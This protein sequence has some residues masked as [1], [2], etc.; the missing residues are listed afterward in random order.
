[1]HCGRVSASELNSIEAS[2]IHSHEELLLDM[3]VNLND[4]TA[5]TINQALWPRIISPI[6]DSTCDD[7]SDR[8]MTLHREGIIGPRTNPLHPT[9]KRDSAYLYSR[10]SSPYFR[11][12]LRWETVVHTGWFQNLGMNFNGIQAYR[13]ILL[14]QQNKGS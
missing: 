5:T 1:M 8:S 2:F 7:L 13:K 4:A 3:M 12:L 14:L 10:F 9:G 6:T 11:C